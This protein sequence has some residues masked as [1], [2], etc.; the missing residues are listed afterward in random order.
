MQYIIWNA[1]GLNDPI[2]VKKVSELIKAHHPAIIAFS[3]T[4]R[5]DFSP[6]VLMALANFGDFCWH[7][8][9]ATGTARGILLGVDQNFFEC[10]P[11]GCGQFLCLL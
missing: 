9:P 4:K 5:V 7:H 3:E 11:L 2:K 10:H 6:Q 1:R 8:L